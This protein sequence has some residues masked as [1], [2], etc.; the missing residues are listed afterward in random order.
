MYSKKHFLT[1]PS[2]CLLSF[3][4]HCSEVISGFQETTRKP[5]SVLLHQSG[6]LL[7]ATGG[8]FFVQEYIRAFFSQWGSVEIH[9]FEVGNNPGD[10]L[11]NEF[12]FPNQN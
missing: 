3:I 11:L 5:S 8:H 6:I 12:T 4:L 10:F 2:S 1:R 9:T 7:P